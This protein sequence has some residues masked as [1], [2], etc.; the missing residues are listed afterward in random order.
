[1]PCGEFAR[2]REELGQFF[3]ITNFQENLGVYMS[4]LL[5]QPRKFTAWQY[6]TVI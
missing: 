4:M 5:A 3:N 6:D 2:L 1:L